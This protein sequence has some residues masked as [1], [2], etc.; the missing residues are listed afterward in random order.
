MQGRLELVFDLGGHAQHVLYTQM[1][2]EQPVDFLGQFLKR[3]TSLATMTTVYRAPSACGFSEE[4]GFEGSDQVVEELLHAMQYFNERRGHVDCSERGEAIR[5]DSFEVKL[6]T[7]TVSSEQ[8][9]SCS[10]ERGG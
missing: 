3:A 2:I 1:C 5:F 6:A 7:S 8:A 9:V 4:G 10:K